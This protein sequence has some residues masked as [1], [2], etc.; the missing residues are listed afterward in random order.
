MEHSC[1]ICERIEVLIDNHH[2]DCAH[3]AISKETA[4]LCRRCHR[5]YHDLGLEWFDDE[6]LDRAIELENRRRKIIYANLENP[7]IPLHLIK[8]EDVKRSPYWN[9]THGIKEEGAEREPQTVNPALRLINRG[10]DPLCGWDWLHEHAARTYP[11]QWI[12]VE[13]DNKPLVKVTS[14]EKRGILRKAM[15]EVS[16]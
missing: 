15:K 12:T 1:Y 4:P 8:R 14:A 2:V 13:Y 3:G 11:E 6:F 10:L 9:K 16:R 5:T 7:V